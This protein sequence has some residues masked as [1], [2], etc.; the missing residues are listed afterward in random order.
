MAPGSPPDPTG[1]HV[2]AAEEEQQ[3][4][5]QQAQSHQSPDGSNAKDAAGSLN[6]EAQEEQ[7]V[8][9][10]D[11]QQ[12]QPD[13]EEEQRAASP[14][15]PER[16]TPVTPGPRAARLQQLYAQSLK[17]TL[18]KLGWDNFAGC[19]PTVARRAEPVLRQVQAQMVDKL[20]DKSEKEFENIMAVRQVVPKLNQLEELLGDAARRR[21]AADPSDPEPTPPHSLPPSDILAAHMHPALVAH[22]SQL[23]A[24]LQTTQSQNALLFDE[25]RRQ[26]EEIDQ[27]LGQLEAAVADVSAANE[28]LAHVVPQIVSEARQRDADLVAGGSGGAPTGG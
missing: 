2:A 14:P 18:A 17:H 24:R 15:L 13:Q 9:S 19:Y 6:A 11:A 4:Q 10:E 16:H 25:V 20:G 28:A 3:Q 26:R 22:Q 5:Q 27:L 1:G 12:Q 21:A 23:N 8:G 7:A